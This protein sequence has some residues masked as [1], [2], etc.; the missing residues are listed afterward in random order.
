MELYC[1]KWFWGQGFNWCS[2]NQYGGQGF[3]WYCWTQYGGQGLNWCSC[4][5]TSTPWRNIHLSNAGQQKQQQKAKIDGSNNERQCV[6]KWQWL[7]FPP[8]LC[9]RTRRCVNVFN[10]SDPTIQQIMQVLLAEIIDLLSTDNEL[11]VIDSSNKTLSFV[12][13]PKTHCDWSLKN[14]KEW[15]DVA[16]KIAGS[17]HGGTYKSVYRIAN[18]LCRF[19]KISVLLHAWPKQSSWASI[20]AQHHSHQCCAHHK[21]VARETIKKET[22]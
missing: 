6:I 19:Y 16:I 8:I 4:A 12:Q 3:N 10:P 20:W 14:S 15:L 1:C 13:V 9:T 21:L 18:Y 2:W 7:W 17:E 11:N 5:T 22:S